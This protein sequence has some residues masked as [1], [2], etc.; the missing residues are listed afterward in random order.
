[1]KKLI[2]ALLCIA[3][4]G[5][6]HAKGESEQE[7]LAVSEMQS[8]KDEN[9]T[10]VIVG[11]ATNQSGETL[12]NAFVKFSLYDAQ[13]KQVGDTIARTV[14]LQPGQAWQFKAPVTTQGVTR[15]QLSEVNTY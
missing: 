3:S 13:N 14:N 12:K 7:P 9:G 8:V 6:V 5:V 11:V 10:P 1:M 4:I 2:A 15:F